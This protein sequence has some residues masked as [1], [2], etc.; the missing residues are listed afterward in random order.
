MLSYWRSKWSLTG[1]IC[2]KPHRFGGAKADEWNNRRF[3]MLSRS[4]VLIGGLVVVL[5]CFNLGYI[6]V[7][8]HNHPDWWEAKAAAEKPAEPLWQTGG[9]ETAFNMMNSEQNITVSLD[10]S[11]DANATDT[12]TSRHY[13]NESEWLAEADGTAVEQERAYGGRPIVGFIIRRT[14][15]VLQEHDGADPET[16]NNEV[17]VDIQRYLLS[18]GVQIVV[19]EVDVG[20]EETE[21]RLTALPMPPA[22]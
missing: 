9:L 13:F 2:P 20:I 10:F 1:D 21:T 5:L 8:N 14:A 6:L 3:L 22:N 7:F 4:K 18:H 16:L 11:W 17:R 12:F 15:A 19:D